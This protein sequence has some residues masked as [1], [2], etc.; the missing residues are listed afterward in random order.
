MSRPLP[1]EMKRKIAELLDEAEVY[2]L[3]KRNEDIVKK[4]I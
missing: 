4:Q 1:E 3:L 2:T